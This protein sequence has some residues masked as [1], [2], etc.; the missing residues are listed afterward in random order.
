MRLTVEALDCLRRP[1]P[2]K[3]SL[4][5]LA[6][7]NFKRFTFGNPRARPCLDT[8]LFDIF[9]QGGGRRSIL[10]HPRSPPDSKAWHLG[11]PPATSTCAT[12]TAPSVAVCIGPYIKAFEVLLQHRNCKLW[13]SFKVLQTP[14]DEYF[15]MDRLRRYCAKQFLQSENQ[16]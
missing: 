11:F 1:W 10:P 14:T 7:N 9:C 15:S 16:P 2:Q 8:Y 13:V 4:Q 3:H 6:Q 5:L 12:N